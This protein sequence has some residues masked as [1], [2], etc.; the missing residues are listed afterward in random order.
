MRSVMFGLTTLV[1]AST[2]YAAPLSVCASGCAF[3]SIQSA[4]DAAAS[5]DSINIAAGR[6]VENVTIAG[7]N[8]QLIGAGNGR[9]T[10]DG[11]SRGSVFTLGSGTDSPTASIQI[12]NLAVTHGLAD[13]GG[14]IDV[15]AGANLSLQGV[16]VVSNQARHQGAGIF[17]NIPT[18]SPATL[19]GCAIE[20]NKADAAD[21]LSVGGGIAISSG[22][23]SIDGSTIA[24]NSARVS[25]GGVSVGQ[26]GHLTLT[27]STVAENKATTDLIDGIY[28]ATGGGISVSA[29][30]LTIADSSIVRNSSAGFAG[31]IFAGGRTN[32]DRSII[33][34]NTAL[35][36]GGLDTGGQGL[37][38]S[39]NRVYVIQNSGGGIENAGSP[40]FLPHSVVADNTPYDCSGTGC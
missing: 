38:V 2:G 36:G 32:V 11:A 3:S 39:L 16:L 4:V 23:V 25:G 30:T 20:N 28:R 24:R 29:G 10:V 31:G 1:L 7:K 33:G 21:Q 34:Q 5:G 26:I 40:L 15:L 6:Y 27:K 17:I 18:H 14:G 22:T 19:S 13:D 9:T 37:A 35:G 8:L 12:S